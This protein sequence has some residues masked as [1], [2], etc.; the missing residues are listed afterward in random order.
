MLGDQRTAIKRLREALECT[1][2]TRSRVEIVHV[3]FNELSVSRAGA[4]VIELLE[5]ELAALPDD[6]HDLGVLL[7]SDVDSSGFLSLPAKRAAEHH[8]RRFDDPQDPGMQATAAMHA[9]LYGG[10]GRQGRRT[11]DQGHRRRSAA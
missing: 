4:R 11:R 1:V 6:E 10:A 9:A 3:L 2:D 7:E 5:R 8:H